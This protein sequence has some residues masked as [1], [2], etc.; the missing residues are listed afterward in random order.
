MLVD[1]FD[2]D[3]VLGVVAEAARTGKIGDGKIWVTPAEAVIRVRTGE[4][5]PDA[6]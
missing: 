1:D 6:L 4:T 5:G 3:Q 2:V